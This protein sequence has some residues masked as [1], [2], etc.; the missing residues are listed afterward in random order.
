MADELRTEVGLAVIK[1]VRQHGY[2]GL[3]ERALDLG[4]IKLTHAGDE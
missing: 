2:P 4:V 3:L 1:T